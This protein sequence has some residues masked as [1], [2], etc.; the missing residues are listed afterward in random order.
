MSTG[1][2]HMICN[3]NRRAK[4]GAASSSCAYHRGKGTKRK[5][6]CNVYITKEVEFRRNS[7]NFEPP[8]ASRMVPR[9]G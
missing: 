8:R 5:R 7:Q 3:H 6:G 9:V 4:A 1:V 2:Y